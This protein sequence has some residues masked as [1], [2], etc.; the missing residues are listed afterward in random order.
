M[1]PIRDACPIPEE[2][3]VIID[4]FMNN[5]KD[6]EIVF[7]GEKHCGSEGHWLE[8]QMGLNPN[9]KNE[10]DI[11]GYEMKKNSPKITFG[12]Y[13]ASEYLFSRNKE[14]LEQLNGWTEKHTIIHD[15]F[16]RYFGTAKIV[17]KTKIDFIN[18]IL[19]HFRETPT[20]IK[21]ISIKPQPII[22]TQQ[23][24]KNYT[25]EMLEKM[26]VVS[27]KDICRNNG[28]KRYSNKKKADIIQL[29][30][31]H[32]AI[33][34]ENKNLQETPIQG[35]YTSQILEDMTITS[36]QDICKANNINFSEKRYSWSGSCVPTYGT[37]NKCGQKLYFDDELNLCIVY[38]FQKDEREEKYSLPLFLQ[39]DIVIT[40]WKKTKLEKH[41]NKKF[42]NKG[43]F[44]CKKQ[45]ATYKNICFGKPF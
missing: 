10:P 28:I 33:P 13:S 17:N 24:A 11:L 32:F 44:I 37:W 8:K 18:L 43:F 30:L 42:N 45:G 21:R 15:D 23:I 4:L 36:L 14:T 26:T 38:S 2:K 12:D 35:K 27:L 29:I 7:T 6:K 39:D 25:F 5:V 20:S 31:S 9:C 1:R 22:S 41:I 16:L 19:T 34:V 40:I 3:Q